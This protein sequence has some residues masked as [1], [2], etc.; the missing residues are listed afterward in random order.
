MIIIQQKQ[1][2]ELCD[3]LEEVFTDTNVIDTI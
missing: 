1:S 3:T 2:Q